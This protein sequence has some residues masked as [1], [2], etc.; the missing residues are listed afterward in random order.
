MSVSPDGTVEG[1]ETDDAASPRE[2]ASNA[3]SETL[4]RRIRE[5]REKRGMSLRVV[6]SKAQV[7]PSLLSQI[8]RG[9]ASPSLVSLVAIADALGVRPGGLLDDDQSPSRSPVVRRSERRVVDDPRCRRE[10]LMHIDDPLL[11]MAELH[12]PP[13]GST[14][15]KLAAHSG[16]DYGYVL[17]GEATV[18]LSSGSH[19]LAAGDFIAFDAS[20]PH[21]LLN[22]SE[23]PLRAVW[24]IAHASPQPKRRAASTGERA[25]RAR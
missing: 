14:R 13:G 3:V 18:E 6:A 8:E 16:R 24:I 21:R 1:D 12:L 20:E 17:E 5:L 23:Q 7:S 11:E 2:R 4:S 15:P 19:V 9:Q 22:R 10:Y 25:T